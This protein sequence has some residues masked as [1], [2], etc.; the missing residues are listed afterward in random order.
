MSQPQAFFE[1]LCPAI[2]ATH[3]EVSRR[4]GGRIAFRVLGE[5]GGDWLLDL[6][7]AEVRRG[8]DRRV[9]LMLELRSEDFLSLMRGALDL[10]KALAAGRV[11]YDG[12]LLALV[13]FGTVL[14][15]VGV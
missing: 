13:R 14:E 7:A 2:L 6:D 1:R 12:D 8:I 4:L 9:D 11:R 15:E 10:S 5:R 3:A